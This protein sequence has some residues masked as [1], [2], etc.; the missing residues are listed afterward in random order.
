MILTLSDEQRK[1]AQADPDGS[2]LVLAGPGTG[3]THTLIARLVYLIETAGMMPGSEILLLSFS[4]A[5]VAEI[6]KRVVEEGGDIT[7]VRA[8]TFDSFATRLL[9]RIDPDGQWVNANYDDRITQAAHFIVDEQRAIDQLRPIR[10]VI[11][12]EIQDVLGERL[13]LVKAIVKAT[14]AGFTMFGDPAQCVYAFGLDADIDKTNAPW[15]LPIWLQSNYPDGI[16]VSTFHENRRVNQGSENTRRA[17]WAGPALLGTCNDYQDVSGNIDYQ[18][19]SGNIAYDRIYEDLI[20]ILLELPSIGRVQHLGNLN[21]ESGQSVAILT[22]TN[23]EALLISKELW[24]RGIAHRM[25]RRATDRALPAWI[26]R[27]LKGLGAPSIGHRSFISQLQEDFGIDLEPEEAWKTLK[28]IERGRSHNS[29]NLQT[30]NDNIVTGTVPDDL[31][32]SNEVDLVI[33]TVHR[34]KG[35][36]FDR[37]FLAM[38]TD[39]SRSDSG[40][41]NEAEEARVLFVALTRSKLETSHLEPPS[42]KG[43]RHHASSLRWYKRG[44]PTWKTLEFEIEGNDT[45]RLEPGAFNWR[46]NQDASEIQN[47]LV[48]KIHPGDTAELALLSSGDDPAETM[49]GAYHGDQLVGLTSE[50]FAWSLHNVLKVNRKWNVKWPGRIHDLFFEAIDTVAGSRDLGYEAGLG[51]SGTWVR[52]RIYGLGKLEF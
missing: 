7:Y 16:Q 36:E 38:G 20:Q 8:I 4:R 50:E 43:F 12:D 2:Q 29:L 34:A 17:L 11:V 13:E 46:G 15:E 32:V 10:H 6:R 48:E 9:S 52:A 39:G 40:D 18:D 5:A 24:M 44:F 45:S 22:R 21:P 31:G 3:K 49:Y 1:V 42:S 30:L 19:V 51:G 47:Y 41:F 37:T 35:R 14:D 26:A 33:S 28:R 27:V 25:E 23:I